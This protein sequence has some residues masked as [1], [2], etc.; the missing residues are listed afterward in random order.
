[1]GWCVDG[2]C[3]R[4]FLLITLIH[5]NTSVLPLLQ[6]HLKHRLVC[7]QISAIFLVVSTVVIVVVSAIIVVVVSSILISSIVVVAAIVVI[8]LLPLIL[9]LILVLVPTISPLVTAIL[10]VLIILLFLL[11]PTSIPTLTL[12]LYIPTPTTSTPISVR[13]ALTSLELIITAPLCRALEVIKGTAIHLE[14]PVLIPAIRYWGGF[15]AA[16]RLVESL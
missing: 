13:N 11:I 10:P 1:M 3:W 12:R 9:V 8:L 6:I 4:T 15:H 2:R 14:R 5:C 16:E 7:I